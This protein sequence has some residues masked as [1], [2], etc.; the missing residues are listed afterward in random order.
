LNGREFDLRFGLATSASQMFAGEEQQGGA[1]N[2][3][4][5]AADRNTNDAADIMCEGRAPTAACTE[6]T[7]GGGDDGGGG[8]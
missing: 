6:S 5:A 2:E 1:E 8:T 4:D 7:G 3:C